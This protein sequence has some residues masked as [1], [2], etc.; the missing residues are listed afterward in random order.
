M[1]T[2]VFI[3]GTIL[4]M[5]VVFYMFYVSYSNKRKTTKLER[6]YSEFAKNLPDDDGTVGPVK[7]KSKKV[8]V[9]DEQTEPKPAVPAGSLAEQNE[10]EAGVNDGTGAKWAPFYQFNI[11]ARD[12]KP[13]TLAQLKEVFAKEKLTYGEFDVFYKYDQQNANGKN[14]DIFRVGNLIKPGTFPPQ[15]S[16]NYSGTDANEDWSTKGICVIM[17][18]PSSRIA[19]NRFVMTLKFVENANNMLDG[20]VCTKDLKPMTDDIIN[21]YREQ[22]REHDHV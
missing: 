19:E 20:L 5:F 21:S 9:V 13:F 6:D 12:H 18:T 10:P 14:P 8:D 1:Q 16:V 17:F 2:V 7:I 3:I 4:V 22:L 11:L 15:L